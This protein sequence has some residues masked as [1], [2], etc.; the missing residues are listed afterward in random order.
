MPLQGAL[1]EAVPWSLMVVVGY[2]GSLPGVPTER[3]TV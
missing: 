3:V 2:K 1:C